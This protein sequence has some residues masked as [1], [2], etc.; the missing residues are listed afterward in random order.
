MSYTVTKLITNAYYLSGIVARDLQTV[1]GQQ[2]NDGLYL[3]NALI[4]AK[5]N[6]RRLIPYFQLYGITLVPDQEV[7]FVPNLI[8]VEVMNFTFNNVRYAMQP[9]SRTQYFG[10]PR[11]NNI[12]TLPFSWYMER[13]KGGANLYLYF[14]PNNDYALQLSGKFSLGEVTLATDLAA[15]LD[16]YYIE[17]L[18][19]A[20][21][22]YIASD[23]NIT[24]QLQN[25]KKLDEYEQTLID[26]SPIDFTNRIAST[27]TSQGGY[28]WGDVNLGGS[29]RPS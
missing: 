13:T 24:F 1:S 16:L 5:T 25:Q 20:L 10:L 14:L 19:Y 26:T 22:E 23:Y 15:T 7:Y 9:L 28:N 3:L 12:S 11:V 6:D 17:Y 27:L 18:R 21:A 2:I 8:G 29:W 4:S